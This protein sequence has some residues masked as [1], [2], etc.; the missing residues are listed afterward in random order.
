MAHRRA[1]RD[2]CRLSSLRGSSRSL[3]GLLSAFTSSRDAL[4]FEVPSTGGHSRVDHAQVNAWLTAAA[5]I[6]T[7]SCSIAHAEGS[8]VIPATEEVLGDGTK[9]SSLPLQKAPR[10]IFVL[11]GPGSGKGTQCAKIVDEFGF[12]HLSAGDLLRAEIKSGSAY[13]NMIQDMIKEGK[14]VPAEVTVGLLQKAMK[15]SGNDKFLIDGFPRNDENRIVFERDTGID[16]EFILFFDC[17]EQ[18]MENRLLGRNQG[19]IDDNIETIR[20]RFKVFIEQSIPVVKHYEARHK[21]CKVDATPHPE[22][23]FKT[24]TPLFLRFRED[25]LMEASKA[26]LLAVDSGN[27]AAYEELCA[28]G[29]TAFEP[30]TKGHLIEGLA[31][32]KFYFDRESLKK[33]TASSP[34]SHIVSPKMAVYGDIGIVTYTRLWQSEVTVKAV[35]ETRIWKWQKNANG[36]WT[37]KNI[38]FHRSSCPNKTDDSL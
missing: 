16:P 20:K 32:H 34:L 10:V 24:I 18:V 22:T 7:Y 15:E 1:L 33:S 2:L 28:S 4:A 6:A 12:T 21:V 38:H 31:F 36:K 37:W 5:G 13:G 25:D 27:Y 9:E 29:L 11:G 35:N 26:L 3:V 30:E 14:I 19:R 23:V 17:P 8:V